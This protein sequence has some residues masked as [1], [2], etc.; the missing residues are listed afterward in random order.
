MRGAVDYSARLQRGRAEA[1]HHLRM[2]VPWTVGVLP[3]GVEIVQTLARGVGK[4][5]TEAL[6]SACDALVVIATHRGR[7]EYRVS[8]AD[9]DIVLTPGLADDGE[10]DLTSLRVTLELLTR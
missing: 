1:R 4:S 3:A 5:R 8:L 6:E 2:D 10:V 7:A 9:A